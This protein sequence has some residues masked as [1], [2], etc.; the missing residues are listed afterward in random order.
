MGTTSPDAG[1]SPR[2]DHR[3]PAAPQYAE[4]GSQSPTGAVERSLRRPLSVGLALALVVGNVLGWVWFVDSQDRRFESLE[5]QVNEAQWQGAGLTVADPDLCWLL[6]AQARAAG[7]ADAFLAA[8]GSEP[9]FTACQEA[10]VHGARG[11]PR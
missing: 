9:Q 2:V 10:A 5:S 7:H 11:E 6:G 1:G 4:H 8:T 3:A